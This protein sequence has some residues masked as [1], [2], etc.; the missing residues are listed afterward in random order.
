MARNTWLLAGALL[1]AAYYALYELPA[2]T[3]VSHTHGAELMLLRQLAFCAREAEIGK[4]I[5][6]AA[7]SRA[8]YFICFDK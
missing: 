1:A 2:P 8:K 6:P 5:P 3:F 4:I 7:A